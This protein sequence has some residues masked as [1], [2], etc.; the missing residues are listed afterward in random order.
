MGRGKTTSASSLVPRHGSSC[1]P[2]QESLTEEQTICTCVS[3]GPFSS[4]PLPCLCLICLPSWPSSASVFYFRNIGWVLKLQILGTWYSRDP[5]WSSREWFHHTMASAAL[6]HKGNHKNHR[7]LEFMV[8]CSKKLESRLAALSRYLC[9]YVNEWSISVAPIGFFVPGEAEP[10][11]P[12][13][14]QAWE[15]SLPVRCRG[16]SDHAVC[17]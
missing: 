2:I 7:G 10:P 3:Q 9:S 11:L 14:F 13:A 4:L 1:L 6:S 12:N 8:K 17:S 15:L 5:S 16:S